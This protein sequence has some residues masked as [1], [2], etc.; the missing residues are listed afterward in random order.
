MTLGP[1]IVLGVGARTMTGFL[2]A[3]VNISAP[4]IVG[5]PRDGQTVTLDLGL[6]EGDVTSFEAAIYDESD[7]VILARQSVTNDSEFLLED[8]VGLTLTLRVWALL[9]GGFTGTADSDPF[10]PIL[11]IDDSGFVGTTTATSASTAGPVSVSVPVDA[12][13]GDLLFVYSTSAAAGEIGTPAGWTDRL[14]GSGH[15]VRTLASWDGT[16]SSYDFT[17]P[18]ATA[19]TIVMVAVRG[20]SWGAI[21]TISGLTANPVPPTFSVPANDSLVYTCVGATTSTLDYSM[22][23]GWTRRAYQGA[24]RSVAVFERDAFAASG[25]LAGET[26]T[27]TSG[28]VNSRALQFS[29]TPA[30]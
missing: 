13:A 25:S 27:R 7:N 2:P 19:V 23:S 17:L 20:Y 11:P 12:E 5:T 16:T 18:G 1:S 29:L 24:N 6:W 10:G 28:A 22:P 9:T 30:P 3:P 14:T 26:V 21:S 8:V 4:E 15:A